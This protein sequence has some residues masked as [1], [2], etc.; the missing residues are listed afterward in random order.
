MNPIMSEPTNTE[1]VEGDKDS[2]VPTTAIETQ[3]V[4]DPIGPP[5]TVNTPID[6][7]ASFSVPVAQSTS[8]RRGIG[9][10][11]ATGA[12]IFVLGIGGG[13][14]GFYLADTYLAD[15]EASSVFAGSS[16]QPANDDVETSAGDEGDDGAAMSPR[17]IYRQVS[18]A[19]V[20]IGT[21]S[22][23][24]DNS[25]FGIPQQKESAGTGSG[26]VIDTD[27]HIVTNAHVVQGANEITVS[28]GDD[29][30]V[31]AKVVGA[32]PSTDI[33]VIKVD[34]GSDELKGEKLRTVQFDDSR[35]VQVGDPVVAIGNPFSLD[36]TLT[37]GVVS[38]LQR[39]IP[40]LNDFQITDVIQTD[41]AVNPGNSGGPLLDMRGRVIGVNSQIQTGGGNGFDGIAFA[42]PSSTA[43]RVAADLIN[44]GEV[45][46][47]WFGL[48]GQELTP[49]IAKAL[50]LPVKSGVIIGEVTP[51]SPAD[52]AGIS[53]G[54]DDVVIEGTG[55]RPGGDIIVSFD[56][57]KVKTMREL[58]ALVDGKE[59]GDKIEVVYYS[60]GKRKTTDVKLGTRPTEQSSTTPQA[61]PG[62]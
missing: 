60:D 4:A 48:A 51:G 30:T 18:P 26:F 49:E 2:T 1:N 16:L 36:R 12:G 27:G 15:D 42:V 62:Q 47:A 32:D 35:N 9:R 57:Q 37:T 23:T 28:F 44:D 58:A 7:A 6:D 34:P 10:K 29:V 53:G 33:A 17:E 61:T 8:P 59:P 43:K 39:E 46:H 50:N 24:T 3:I 41:A 21:K 22:T 54:S 40:S 14:L 20:H 25:F 11:L 55:I 19:V 38:A 5:P 56:G 52:K 13:M 31:P 45:S